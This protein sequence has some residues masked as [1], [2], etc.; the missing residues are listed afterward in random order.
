MRITARSVDTKATKRF[1]LDAQK[2]DAEGDK[3]VFNIRTGLTHSELKYLTQLTMSDAIEAAHAAF[4]MVTDSVENCQDE[5]GN[6][7]EI[8]K[9][10]HK[11]AGVY[12]KFTEESA[13]AMPDIVVSEISD[14]VFQTY[15][16]LT[17]SDIKN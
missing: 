2:D 13:T 7:F 3:L 14:H 12:R 6:P 4:Q 16:T 5:D 17:R 8:T 9:E 10:K 15:F 1:T 11:Y